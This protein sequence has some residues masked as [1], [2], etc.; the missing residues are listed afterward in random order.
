MARFGYAAFK[1]GAW[2]IMMQSYSRITKPVQAI[3]LNESSFEE[4]LSF[5]RGQGIKFVVSSSG[6]KN[7]I[8]TQ[9]GGSYVIVRAG[10][11]LVLEG[12]GMLIFDQNEFYLNF[13]CLHS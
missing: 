13:E 4:C 9:S 3:Q 5:L 6:C 8:S 11:F 2:K 10:D 12:D 7:A 1:S